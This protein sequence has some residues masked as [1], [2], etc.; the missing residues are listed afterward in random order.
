MT[1][2]SPEA[3]TR[4]RQ[5]DRER[6]ATPE[7]PQAV[8]AIAPGPLMV[9][10]FARIVAPR[11]TGRLGGPGRVAV[12]GCAVNAGAQLLWLTQIQAQPAYVTHLLPLSSWGA[13]GRA[14]DSLTARLRQRL[15]HAGQVRHRERDPEHGAPDR[16]RARGGRTGSDPFP[17]VPHRPGP[18]LPP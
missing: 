6:N 15:A 12:L 10:P 1:A 8:Q 14:D 16:H 13:P 7:T 2:R 4:K 17:A 3:V 11:L 9:L 5:R 18:G